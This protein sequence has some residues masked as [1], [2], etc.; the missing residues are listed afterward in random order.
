MRFRKIGIKGYRLLERGNRFGI[1]LL[2]QISGA[3]VVVGLCYR[4]HF[5]TRH[6]GS[7]EPEQIKFGRDA[8]DTSQNLASTDV[9]IPEKNCAIF[10]AAGE[11]MPTLGKHQRRNFASVSGNDCFVKLGI[12]IE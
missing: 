1:L 7:P 12:K 2:V 6:L 3:E 9:R 10:A 4:I 11:D 8:K 5:S